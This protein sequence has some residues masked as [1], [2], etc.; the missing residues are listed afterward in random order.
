MSSGHLYLFTSMQCSS[1]VSFVP[2]W[3]YFENFFFARTS[4]WNSRVSARKCWRCDISHNTEIIRGRE[5]YTWRGLLR[6]YQTFLFVVFDEI[7]RGI[8]SDCALWFV[9]S[10]STFF[11]HFS[12]VTIWFSRQTSPTAYTLYVDV[13][14]SLCEIPSLFCSHRPPYVLRFGLTRESFQHC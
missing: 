3:K 5:I 8:I 9:C 14:P 4:H 7:Q 2:Y 6:L 13:L 1:V 10:K 11:T 12:G